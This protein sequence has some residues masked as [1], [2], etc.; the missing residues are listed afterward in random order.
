MRVWCLVAGVAA[1]LVGL[2]PER[3]WSETNLAA[4]GM[5]VGAPSV[6][7]GSV[8]RQTILV[9]GKQVPLPDGDWI[10]AGTGRS[11]SAGQPASGPPAAASSPVAS[12]VL[13]HV[14]DHR[15]DAAVLVQTNREEARLVWGRARGCERTDLYYARV[16]Y[17]SDHDGSC[18]YA[19]YV[20]SA[21][22]PDNRIDPAWSMA[23]QTAAAKGWAVPATWVDVA[24]R[25][26]DPRDVVQVRYLFD[27]WGADEL[28]PRRLTASQV[29][30][31]V[32]WTE[33]NWDIVEAGFRNRLDEAQPARMSA[34]PHPAEAA[35][36]VNASVPSPDATVTAEVSHL[37]AKTVTYRLFGTLTDLS[38]NYLWLGNL[39]SAGGLAV[40]SAAASSALYFVHE[41]V[42][43]RFEKPADVAA[44]LPGVGDEG[45]EPLRR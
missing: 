2:Q 34:W 9:E 43:S 7:G 3:A 39:P 35:G 29:R 11:A 26:T 5:D 12:V 19:A 10:V 37:G 20:R 6:V 33:A 40:V 45:P 38:V 16:R 36:A 15:I 22:D 13:L 17:A 14:R 41:Y 42:W 18:A 24:F 30:S 8:V 25:V 1:L 27:P 44:N 31:L 28:V 4:A 21:L 32:G 23:R